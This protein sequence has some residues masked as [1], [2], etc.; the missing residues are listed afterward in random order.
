MALYLG[1]LG[2]S[3]LLWELAQLPL[4]TVI[5][6]R[7]LAYALYAA[8]HC[9]GGDLLI[10]GISL[11]LAWRLVGSGRWPAQRQRAVATAA[12]AAGLVYTAFSE[13]M[14]TQVHGTWTYSELMPV[15]PW[16]GIGLT[17]MLQ[18][19]LLPPLCLTAAHALERF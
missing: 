16:L 19:L 6:D 15:L 10:G 5:D 18:W 8:L 4:F 12:T 13:W 1:L 7:G 14:N 11:G 2:A 3:N 9:T 17:P